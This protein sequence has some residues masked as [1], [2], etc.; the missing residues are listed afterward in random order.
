MASTANV[1]ALILLLLPPITL[2]AG[3]LHGFR[4][5]LTRIHQLSPGKHS[6][7]VRRDR[8]RLALLSYATAT[9][10]GKATN[11]SVNVQAQLENGAGA[12]NM[13]LSVGTPP[14][15][16]PVIVDTGS[17]L[18]WTQC[19]PCTRCFPRPTP[20]PVLQ[21]ARSS[22]FSKLPCNSSFCQSL[23]TSSRPRTCSNATGCAYNYTYGSGY[24]AG[25]LATETLT[26]GDGTFPKV[27]FGCS[28]ENGVY[29]SS[30]IV[31]LGRGVLS[32]MS[33]LTVGRF[34]YCLRSDMAASGASPILFGSLAKLTDGNVQSTPLLKNPFLLRSSHYYVNLTGITVGST[35]LPVTGSTFG[36]TQTGLGGGTIVDSGTTLTYLAKDGYAMVKQAFTSQMANVTTAASGAPYDLDLCFKAKGGEV[37]R[38]PRLELRFAGGAKYDVPVQ[39]Y[40]AGVETDSRGRVTVACLLVLPTTD[41]LPISIIGNL[42]QMDM[43]VLYDLDGGMFSFAH[44]DCAK[45]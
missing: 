2:A 5:T 21:P 45:L 35:E 22:T 9:A 40:F 37:V 25:Y 27:A 32:L 6:E 18:I 20:A 11:S 30:G 39:N 8:H 15:D 28:T 33:Q 12:Y 23:P 29:N 19:A 36:F 10:A 7:A 4:A 38:V 24:T 17:D 14:I 13:N 42:M 44:T 26:V 43:H 1:L 41:D 31:G 16:F 3:D 34:S